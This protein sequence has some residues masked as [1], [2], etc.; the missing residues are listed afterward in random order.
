LQWTLNAWSQAL[1]KDELEYIFFSKTGLI[2][3]EPFAF[4]YILIET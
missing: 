4:H 3:S 1:I 2:S